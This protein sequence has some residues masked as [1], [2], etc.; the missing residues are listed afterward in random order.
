MKGLEAAAVSTPGGME[1][2]TFKPR[3]HGAHRSHEMRNNKKHY[4]RP[5][6]N[7][8]KNQ[9]T[10]DNNNPKVRDNQYVEPYY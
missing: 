7:N 9:K 1:L 3:S 5:Y 6:R 8:R 10:D 2:A 4:R